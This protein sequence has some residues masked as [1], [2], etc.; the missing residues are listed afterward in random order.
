M[1]KRNRGKVS[2]RQNGIRWAMGGIP[3]T[4]ELKREQKRKAK[5]PIE[6]CQTSMDEAR[7]EDAG[8]P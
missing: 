6:D 8:W 3:N 2:A 5:K 1:S 4:G 7:K